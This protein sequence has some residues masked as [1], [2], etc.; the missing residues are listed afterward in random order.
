MNT[1]AKPHPRAMMFGV[2]DGLHEGHRHMISQALA[3][4]SHLTIVL[5]KDETVENLKHK[6]PRNS[7]EKRASAI[8]KFNPKISVVEGDIILG[9]WT[10]LKNQKPDVVFLGYDQQKI[11]AE[12]SKLNIQNASDIKLVFLE[13]YKPDIYKSSLLRDKNK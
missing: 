4:S 11:A 7:Y 5:A 13:P 9:S 1:P 12:L 10:A 8:L 6:T 2:F 3:L